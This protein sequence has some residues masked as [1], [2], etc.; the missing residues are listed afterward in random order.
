MSLLMTMLSSFFRDKTNMETFL[1]EP[2]LGFDEPKISERKLFEPA[3]S[4]AIKKS[5]TGQQPNPWRLRWRGKLSCL[6]HSKCRRFFRMVK[7]AVA[8]KKP[9]DYG[10]CPPPESLLSQAR[11]GNGL[12]NT[13]KSPFYSHGYPCGPVVFGRGS[14]FMQNPGP[15]QR[16]ARR[17]VL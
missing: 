3:P 6:Q 7:Q 12:Q 4:N 8:V 11:S 17:T 5:L 2:K 14:F 15:W 10:N 13:T 16:L 1:G 9:E